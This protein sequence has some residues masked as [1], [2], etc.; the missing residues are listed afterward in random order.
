M[1][2]YSADVLI[3]SETWFKP[4]WDVTLKG[5]DIIRK[6][7]FRGKTGCA[8][9]VSSRLNY[10][11]L[12]INQNFNDGTMV[13]G[14]TLHGNVGLNILSVYR[15]QHSLHTV[16]DWINIFSQCPPPCVIGGDFNVHNSLFGSSK[17]DSAGNTLINAIDITSLVALNNGKPTHIVK[18]PST[19]KSAVDVTLASPDIAPD[20]NWDVV[21]ESLGSDHFLITMQ[22]HKFKIKENIT[23]YPRTKW[24]TRHANWEVFRGMIDSDLFAAPE[25]ESAQ[26][27][28]R[29]LSDSIIRAANVAFRRKNPVVLRRKCN[30]VWWSD[31]CTVA[32]KN[33]RDALRNYKASPTLENFMKYQRIAAEAKRVLKTA[34][35]DSWR[36]FC[37]NLNSSSS[38]SQL[39]SQIR[40]MR[41]KGLLSSRE[42]SN[43]CA[44]AILHSLTPD[45]VTEDFQNNGTDN[46][47][48]PLQQPF[49]L[50]ELESILKGRANT[51]P[52][53]DSITYEMI[54]NLPLS[55]KTFLVNIFS[56]IYILG[57]SVDALKVSSVILIHKQ[58]K[59][60]Q[61]PSSYRP[62]SL[63]SCI[64]KLMEKMIKNRLEWWF[65]FKNIRF[66]YQFGFKKNSNTQYAAGKLITDIQ[67]CF[68]RNNYLGA[69]FL[70]I[71]GAY[72]SVNLS[73]LEA[74]LTKLEIP[75][76]I[77]R[78]ICNLY[79][80]RKIIIRQR[81]NNIIG[82]RFT[83]IGLPQGSVLSPTLFNIYTTDLQI[84]PVCN[85]IQYADDLV[86]YTESK[87]LEKCIDDVQK[88]FQ[89]MA[90]WLFTKGL[91]LSQEKT[92]FSIFTR[93]NIPNHIK[94]SSLAS[95]VIYKS[96][97]KYLGFFLD[98]KLTWR[99][100]IDNIINKG[101]KVL[102]VIRMV[103]RVS[104]VRMSVQ[105]CAFIEL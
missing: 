59:P 54:H 95:K 14:I 53:E 64:L 2:E 32:I 105:H 40:K 6:D 73:L 17:N 19:L 25:F 81:N 98:Q 23:V 72:N 66:D 90:N 8:I 34:A 30:P 80:N 91:T 68:S 9:C 75:A 86:L 89:A 46:F 101:E 79:R 56:R 33:R 11:V 38:S 7:H 97:I 58:G 44:E 18:P 82:P 67:L 20:I 104:G 4:G 10:T 49:Q 26:S 94:N 1:S 87:K 22:Y 60:V 50:S 61:S 42:C 71:E 55:A 45:Y 57:E 62:I 3:L 83:S 28:Y 74:N 31:I 41:G 96:E 27:M 16:N 13:C 35:R 88:I 69:I 100:H 47:S 85:I 93:H 15:P 70:D 5:Y 21:D 65:S 99:K 76:N 12:D 36:T 51:A 43:E 48:H 52:G 24:D 29:Y 39:W 102:N 77:S 92:V 103:T 84:T 37:E 78:N 63:L